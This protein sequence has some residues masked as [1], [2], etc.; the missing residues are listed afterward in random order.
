M[1]RFLESKEARR[2]FEEDITGH[3]RS[4]SDDQLAEVLE[5]Q[6]EAIAKDKESTAG[7]TDE[8]DEAMP[9]APVP[10][11]RAQT[12]KEYLDAKAAGVNSK[13]ESASPGA[14]SASASGSNREGQA[15]APTSGFACSETPG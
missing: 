2:A 6:H 1:R 9:A 4:Q 12:H 11:D 3:S 14:K 8:A 7:G 10:S 15:P 5:T 13:T